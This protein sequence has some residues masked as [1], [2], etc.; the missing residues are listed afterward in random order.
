M[1][2]GFTA[3]GPPAGGPLPISVVIPAY[4]AA[5]YL[6]EA[7]ASVRAQTRS[8][9]EVIVVDNGSTDDSPSIA[10]KAGARLLRLER[11][12]LS[13]ARNAGILAASQPWIA[14][15]DA[16]D[17]WDPEK[18]A[19]QWQAVESC[20]GVGIV[21]TDFTEFDATGILLPSFLTGA[22]NYQA[23]SRREIMPAVMCC[24]SASFRAHFLRGNFFAPA[25]ILAR[26]DLLVDV[27]LFDEALTH[28]EDRELWLR[29]L[30]RT[31][32]AVI[33]RP[34]LHT[35]IHNANWSSNDLKMALCGALIA[36]RVLANPGRYPTGALD[37]YRGERPR[38]YL[39]AGRFAEEAGDMR[40]ARRHYLRA[41]RGGGGLRPL[42]LAMLSC[43]PR[44]LRLPVRAALHQ[45][46][47][48]A[49]VSRGR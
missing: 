29:M 24:D 39:N 45:P 15:L 32:V 26:R 37:Y 40:E 1:S 31:V 9:A 7:L 3:G 46:A 30:P 8:P 44:A 10:L 34:L 13:A 35:R 17:L 18:L 12:S 42:V 49:H 36:E 48:V 19:W 4:N 6:E 22:A 41:W 47:P 2:Q 16:D 21:T 25:A 28:M 14:L 20:P 11:P 43:L 27:G 23:I 33:E 38:F 5:A